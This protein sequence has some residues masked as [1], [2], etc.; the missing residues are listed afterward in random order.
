[1]KANWG[2]Q[3][4]V[5]RTLVAQGKYLLC[6]SVS[7]ESGEFWDSKNWVPLHLH[8]HGRQEMIADVRKH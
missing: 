2:K 4:V 1:M 8:Q 7:D 5:K 3:G 6:D